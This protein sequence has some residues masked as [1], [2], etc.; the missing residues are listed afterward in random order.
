[1]NRPSPTA[2]PDALDDTDEVDLDQLAETDPTTLAR[3]LRAHAAGLLADTAAVE[4]LITHR[5]W[6]TRP[7]FTT[8]FVHLVTHSGQLIGAYLDWPAAITA[9]QHGQLACSSSQAD[10]LRIAAGL[11]ADLPLTL[12]HVLGGL[13]HPTI[14][15]VTAALTAANGTT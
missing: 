1:M 4:L 7:G 13:D 10:L 11:G 2:G 15:A 12:R 6:L 8:R 9:L 5:Y 3:L 14:T